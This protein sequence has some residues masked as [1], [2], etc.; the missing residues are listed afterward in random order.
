[1][2]KLVPHGDEGLVTLEAEK[3]RDAARPAGTIASLHLTVIEIPGEDQYGRKLTSCAFREAKTDF[4]VENLPEK[5]A[6]ILE[7]ISSGPLKPAEIIEK[8][9][10]TENAWDGALKLFKKYGLVQKTR[11][12]YVRVLK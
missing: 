12:G 5:T 8:A 3:I 10:V 6:R 7:I 4:I 1:M 9:K 2:L 11:L